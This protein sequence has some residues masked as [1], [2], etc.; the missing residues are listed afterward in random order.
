VVPVFGAAMA[1]QAGVVARCEVRNKR[2]AE[3]VAGRYYEV[4]VT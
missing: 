3:E 2:A 1:A 4:G